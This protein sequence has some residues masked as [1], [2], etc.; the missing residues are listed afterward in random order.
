[1]SKIIEVVPYDPSWPKVFE[2]AA[3]SIREAL[4]DNCAEIHHIGSTAVPGLCAKRKIDMIAVVKDPVSV[5]EPLKK[6]GL[7]Y[8]G[9]YN[10]PL[11]YFFIKRGAVNINLHVYPGGH[12]E[13][14]LNL[15]FRDYLRS[16]QPARDEYA[17]LKKQLLSD[18]SS[19]EKNSSVFTNYT[20]RKGDFIRKILKQAGWTRLRVLKCNEEKEWNAVRDFRQKYFF[21]PQSI[22]DPYT[23]TFNHQE[24]EHLILYQGVEIIGYTHIQLWPDERAAMRILV[25]DEEKRNNNYGSQF[26]KLCEQWLR[27]LGYKSLHAESRPTSIGFYTKN[28]YVKMPFNDPEGYESAPQ[29]IAV[30]K[31]L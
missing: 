18:K 24:H 25:I 7:Q 13:I 26:L 21:A 8:K 15:L 2:F 14:E 11:R 3:V 27:K 9:E 19:F 5:I 16:N 29:D 4:R 28:N 17:I 10:I 30:G 20:L 23:W 31:I 6:F 22:A 1:M 12:P